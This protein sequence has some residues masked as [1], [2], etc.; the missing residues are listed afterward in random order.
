MN[1]YELWRP[2]IDLFGGLKD[3][4][5]IGAF[6]TGAGRW[7]KRP[8][9]PNDVLDHLQGKGPGIG[10]PPL[11]PDNTVVFASIDLDEPDFQAARDMQQWIPGSSYVERSRSGNAHIHVFFDE[12]IEAWVPMG[13]LKEATK[14]A[15]KEHV[16]VFP[17]NHDFSKVKFGNYINLPYF[18]KTRPV[19][20]YGKIDWDNTKDWIEYTLENFIASV[21]NRGLNA[22][23]EWHKRARWLQI[24]EPQVRE[25][26]TE[27][28]KV[29][30]M[31]AEYIVDG[32]TSGERPITE[33]HRSA[34]YFALSSQLR[35]WEDLS[36]DESWDLL[37]ECNVA[38]PDP[39]DPRELRRIF[40]NAGSFRSTRC[41]DPL[42]APFTHPDCPIARS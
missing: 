30:H 39:M 24:V 16:E 21:C 23:E 5:A 18:G 38:S 32:A 41:D 40:N 15:G 34:V 19:L 6:G 42:V 13:I 22:P 7:V 35:A 31:C 25:A 20:A 14:A 11:R 28:Q 9:S 12:P 10:V 4:Q 1:V 2:F 29:L 27:P 26:S 17:K 3:S 8:L 37:V 33:G 36:D